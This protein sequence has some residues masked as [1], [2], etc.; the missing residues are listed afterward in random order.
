MSN[1]AKDI[2]WPLDTNILVRVVVLHVGQGASAVVLIADGDTY[3][4]LL[5]DINLDGKNDG[6]DVPRLMSDL[7][8]DE[9]NRLDVFVNTH[10]H[11]DHLSGIGELSDA[12]VIQEVWH[13]G[14]KP[15]KDHEGAYKDLQKLIETVNEAGGTETQ[16]KGSRSPKQIGD[17]E[18]YVFAPAQ[19]VVDDIEGES[20]D[21]RYR[22]IHEQC[23]VL[24]FGIG[25]NWILMTGDADRDAWEKHIANYHSERLSADILE[26]AHHGSRTFFRYN[27][28][29]EPNLDALKHISPTYVVISAPRSDES[30]WGH[31]HE[32]AL[33]FYA[34]A[35]GGDNILHTGDKRHSFICDIFRDGVYAIQSDNGDL[36]NTYSI[37]DDEDNDDGDD[38][39]KSL[40]TPAVVGTRVD[41]RPMGS[42]QQ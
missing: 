39:K 3:R 29:D 35:V 13:S 26:A 19:Y 12:L 8:E 31:P 20:S 4:S 14:H 7:L 2:I 16:L 1:I 15:G 41:R 27:E 22:R 17:A 9:N 38:R 30:Q 10:P 6:I 18:Y 25:D 23:A 32:D 40:T 37:E 36:A 34:D 11:S 21:E 24:K 42:C 28:E 5:I 33:E